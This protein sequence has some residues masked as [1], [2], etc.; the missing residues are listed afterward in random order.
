MWLFICSALFDVY[1]QRA[2]GAFYVS[3]DRYVE[4]TPHILGFV[5]DT[6]RRT[7][8]TTGNPSTAL[9]ASPPPNIVWLLTEACKDAQL[10]HDILEACNQKLRDKITSNFISQESAVNSY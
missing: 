7:N 8:A 2:N 9:T 4:C 10:W 5:D 1:C 6:C 3:L